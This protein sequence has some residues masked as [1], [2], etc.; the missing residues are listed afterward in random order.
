MK[1]D[2]KTNI[3]SSFLRLKASTITESVVAMTVIS[4]SFTVGL[5]VFEYGFNG[6]L[7]AFAS[8]YVDIQSGVKLNY[9]SV[10]FLQ[11]DKEEIKEPLFLSIDSTAHVQGLVA[12]IDQTAGRRRPRIKILSKAT[13]TGEFFSTDPFS[14][15]GSVNGTV[16][17]PGFSLEIGMQSC[18]LYTSPS[19]RDGL[20]SRMPSS[21]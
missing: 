1:W 17:S 5:K 4:I 20:L 9:P 6:K 2:F 21:A 13:I 3:R 12:C 11:K 19:P 10:I 14:L 7:Q 15:E 18:L 8:Q 16:I